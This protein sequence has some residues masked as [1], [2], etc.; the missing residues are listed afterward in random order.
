MDQT[1]FERIQYAAG[2]GVAVV[3]LNRPEKRNALDE[4]TIAELKEALGRAGADEAVKAVLLTSSSADFCAGADVAAL[5]KTSERSILENRN[6]ARS[7]M[8]LFVAMRR[9]PKPIVAAV[10]G[11]AFAG[12]AGLATACDVVLAARSAQ[13]AYTEIRLGFVPAIV[14]AMLRRAVS[15]KVAFELIVRGEPIGAERA[16]EIGLITR[17]FDDDAFEEAVR[18]YLRGLASAS[19][20]A[21]ALSKYL[22][23]QIDGMTFDAAVSAGADV[24]ALAR[25]TEDFRAGI[26]RFLD[27]Q[28]K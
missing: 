28:S 16:A 14:M 25:M 23:Y 17:V 15:E 12:G 9:L 10:R 24:N 21:V 22:L 7:L 19:A 8:D 6:D 13:F 3:T 4:R 2:G 26:A 27:R 20:S 11:R 5:Q 18:E 1:T